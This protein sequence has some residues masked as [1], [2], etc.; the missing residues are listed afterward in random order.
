MQEV[1]YGKQQAALVQYCCYSNVNQAMSW[2]EIKID[3]NSLG[4]CSDRWS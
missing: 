2:K 3:A 1:K 4:K